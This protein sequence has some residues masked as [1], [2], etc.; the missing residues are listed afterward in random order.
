MFEG[1]G[2][3]PKGLYVR[4]RDARVGVIL[5]INKVM[6]SI[7]PNYTSSFSCSILHS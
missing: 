4:S 3:V 5:S 2:K 1:K 6:R 7:S